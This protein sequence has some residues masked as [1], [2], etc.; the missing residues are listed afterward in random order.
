M[1]EPH[2]H[3]D[4]PSF[5]NLF[6]LE[7]SPASAPGCLR[8]QAAALMSRDAET[9][10]ATWVVEL[11]AGWAGAHDPGDGTLELVTLSG[12]LQLES[13]RLGNG[14][15]FRLP[16]GAGAELRTATGVLAIAYWA[17]PAQPLAAPSIPSA[18]RLI[19]IPWQMTDPSGHGVAHRSLRV[20]DPTGPPAD[21]GANGFL[22]LMAMPSG[23]DAPYQHA[24]HE[25]FEELICLSGDLLLVDEGSCAL[26]SVAAHPRE[27]WHGPFASRSGALCL[28][29]TDAAMGPWPTRDYPAQ[30]AIC[31][32]YLD[33][34]PWDALP[35]HVDWDAT[36]WTRLQDP[37][38]MSAWR[39]SPEGAAFATTPAP[40]SRPTVPSGEET[41]DAQPV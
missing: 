28:V 5:Y 37:F 27:W 34:A 13:E 3:R 32:A 10:C 41:H 15:Y 24:H 16:S 38:T 22:R 21:G 30:E 1:R 7:R 12:A 36:P 35:E 26:G 19:D 14:S 6:A 8:G 17:P 40:G 11:P 23:V 39:A 9:D 18:V 20:P 25:C 2:W 31:D 33:E 4:R 29:Q